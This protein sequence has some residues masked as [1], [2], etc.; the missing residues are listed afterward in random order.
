MMSENDS[1]LYQIFVNTKTNSIIV[2]NKNKEINIGKVFKER[3]VDYITGG[4]S[5]FQL[6]LKYYDYQTDV[7]KFKKFI[8]ELLGDK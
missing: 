8:V 4:G 3:K 6:Q 2:N 7:P 1:N 5:P